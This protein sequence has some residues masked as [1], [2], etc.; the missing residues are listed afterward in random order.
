MVTVLAQVGEQRVPVEGVERGVEEV[1]IRLKDIEVP[2][3]DLLVEV[4]ELVAEPDAEHIAHRDLAVEA[5]RMIVHE[6]A[7]VDF[8]V[9]RS[10]R[11][12]APEVAL[13]SRIDASPAYRHLEVAAAL[14]ELVDELLCL[15]K[16]ALS[17][18]GNAR[19]EVLEVHL[20]VQ[21]AEE[22]P[23]AL[24]MV[25][26]K[27]PVELGEVLLDCL[28]VSLEADRQNLGHPAFEHC[29]LLKIVPE[30][31]RLFNLIVK[32]WIRSH[33][34]VSSAAGKR[35]RQKNRFISLT[36]GFYSFSEIHFFTLLT[37]WK[38][39]TWRENDMAKY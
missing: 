8:A 5:D 6:P 11:A 24:E 17:V 22:L 37:L 4:A 3:P 1:G 19:F 36:C 27:P 34:Q 32:R 20:A 18:E 28:P 10:Q 38:N 30:L 2:Y 25:V 33:L 16:G 15:G 35:P 7:V 26:L 29:K 14:Q 39:F 12:V 31:F 23:L 9:V 13:V 21:G